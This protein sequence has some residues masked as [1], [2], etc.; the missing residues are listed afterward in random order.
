MSPALS[1]AFGRDTD[2][3]GWTISYLMD[4]IVANLHLWCGETDALNDTL[5]LLISL[6]EKKER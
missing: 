4:K 6:V 1:A 2:G 3:G 5:E